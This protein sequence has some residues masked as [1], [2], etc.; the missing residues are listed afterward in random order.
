M[1]TSTLCAL[2]LKSA[3]RS[4]IAW[5]GA[6]CRKQSCSMD[7]ETPVLPVTSVNKDS[8]LQDDG[9]V[10]APSRRGFLQNKLL[11]GG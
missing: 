7:Q 5:G 10:E 3:E 2:V 11:L 1:E 6:I 8:D 9:S 4:D